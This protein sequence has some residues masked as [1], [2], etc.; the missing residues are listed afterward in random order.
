M[1]LTLQKVKNCVIKINGEIVCN[2]ENGILCFI[3]FHKN[4]KDG[5]ADWIARKALSMFYWPAEDDTPWKRGVI[6]VDGDVV[7]VSEPGLVATVD[8]DNK[9]SFENVMN[10]AE[11]S[12]MYNKL[13]AKLAASYKTEKI[14]AIPL[15]EK[16]T[17]E[18]IN[19]GPLTLSIDSY[20]RRD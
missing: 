13:I 17:M 15:N 19:D 11:T 14:H 4:D 18:F 8:F 2:I 5:D 9:P 12:K 20:R 1:K 3:G 6:D 10:E 7:V 16:K